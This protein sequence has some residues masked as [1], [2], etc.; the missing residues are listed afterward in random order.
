M[1]QVAV[2]Y[3]LETLRQDEP[4]HTSSNDCDSRQRISSVF[5]HGAKTWLQIRS[6]LDRSPGARGAGKRC[7]R[8]GI[9]IC[10]H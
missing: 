3:L 5:G 1:E 7:R 6:L 2:E 10:A 8:E 9:T 4:T